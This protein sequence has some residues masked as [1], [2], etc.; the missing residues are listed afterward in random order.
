[1]TKMLEK[2]FAEVSKLPEIEQNKFAKWL[3]DEL[4][5]E[6]DWEAVFADSEEFL[7]HLA[8]EAL[9]EHRHGKTR[10]MDHNIL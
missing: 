6:K 9:S 4:A 5:A 8:D 2:A 1:M 3:L 7:S 10:P